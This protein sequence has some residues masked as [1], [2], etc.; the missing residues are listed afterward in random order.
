MKNPDKLVARCLFLQVPFHDRRGRTVVPAQGQTELMIDDTTIATWDGKM[1]L[2]RTPPN[3]SKRL[4]NAVNNFLDIFYRAGYLPDLYEMRFRK[5]QVVV[6]R[7]GIHIW[8]TLDGSAN[9]SYTTTAEP[10]M[11]VVTSRFRTFTCECWGSDYSVRLPN[12]RGV[13][14]VAAQALKG[15]IATDG[16]DARYTD[17]IIPREITLYL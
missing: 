2:V 7:N 15:Q 14:L 9:F 11:G 8:D 6:M 13:E 16:L 17:V 1:L 4:L 10:G 12:F 5:K 3:P